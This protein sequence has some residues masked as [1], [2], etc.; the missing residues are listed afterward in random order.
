MHPV[1]RGRSPK[2]RGYA[3][4][5]LHPRLELTMQ[6]CRI[7]K[8]VPPCGVSIMSTLHSG[9]DI[10]PSSDSGNWKGMNARYSSL[11]YSIE[12]RRPVIL[13][14]MMDK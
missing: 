3:Y 9:N 5:L 2:N 7:A 10:A 12:Y 8:V 4:H 1:P 13:Y 14:L 11:K 6:R